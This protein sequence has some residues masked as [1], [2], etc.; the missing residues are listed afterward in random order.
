MQEGELLLGGHCSRTAFSGGLYYTW[1]IAFI[2]C[3]SHGKMIGSKAA[4][5]EDT[6]DIYSNTG[7]VHLACYC[8][9]QKVQCT[10]K[11]GMGRSHS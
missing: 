5:T 7:F 6:T 11:T 1:Y 8:H 10:E 9:I 4:E 3:T 2:L